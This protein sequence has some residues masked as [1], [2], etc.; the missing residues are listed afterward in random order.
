[1]EGVR[2]WGL[3]VLDVSFGRSIGVGSFPFNFYYDWDFGYVYKN[4]K[5]RI[6]FKAFLELEIP[7]SIALDLEVGADDGVRLYI[8]G[9]LVI[10]AWALGSYR[11]FRTLYPLT[12][13]KHRLELHYF[14]WEGVAKVKFAADTGALLVLSTLTAKPNL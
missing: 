6:G 5:D 9:E 12:A 8:D 11:K 13:G 3:S 7:A 10:D 2:F 4:H 1:M 14:E